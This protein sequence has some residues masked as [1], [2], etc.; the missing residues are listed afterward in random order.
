LNTRQAWNTIALHYQRQAI[1]RSS[2]GPAIQLACLVL[3]DYCTALWS[4]H[5]G[6]SLSMVGL[7]EHLLG[8]RIDEVVAEA[9]GKIDEARRESAS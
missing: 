1:V 8:D 2:E 7:A 5:R 6:P 3:S 4:G 9:L